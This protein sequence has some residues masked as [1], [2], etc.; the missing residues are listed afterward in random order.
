M[1]NEYDDTILE[2]FV[3]PD[4]KDEPPT[5]WKLGALDTLL[6]VYLKDQLTSF[7]ISNNDPHSLANSVVNINAMYLDAVRFGLKGWENF[8]SKSGI[9]EYTTVSIAIPKVGNRQGLSEFML[10]KL[11]DSWIKIMGERIL[12]LSNINIGSSVDEERKN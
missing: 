1:A 6:R 7:N 9:I 12:K 11:K 2:E 3:L 8:K 5:K 10:R 4:D